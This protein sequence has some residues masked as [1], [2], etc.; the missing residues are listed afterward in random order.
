[1]G[2]SNG[3]AA[4]D[5]Y[6]TSH[7]D[8]FHTF[9]KVD[10]YLFTAQFD[11]TGQYPLHSTTILAYQAQDPWCQDFVNTT[12]HKAET[13][14]YKGA[15]VYQIKQGEKW[16]V[17]IPSNVLTNLIKWYHTISMHAGSSNLLQI[18]QGHF[19][20][21]QLKSN[22]ERIVH[23]CAT[24]QRAKAGSGEYGELAARDP[25]LKPWLEVHVDCM[26]PWTF[27]VAEKDHCFSALTCIDPAS[28]LLEVLLTANTTATHIA[29]LFEQCWLA[30]YPRPQYIVHNNGMEFIGIPFQRMLQSQGIQV[31]HISAY[32]PTANAY[33][34]RTHQALANA[35]RV[36][37][38]L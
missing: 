22:V 6:L 7:I 26:G 13:R 4:E 9:A 36:M 10:C 1:L 21:P 19:F 28:A 8:L 14:E 17:L 37:L 24:C 5:T 25:P 20:H 27:T 18:M 3:T 30:R 23:S 2:E 29:R 11:S 15:R 31:N 35:L 34:E 12:N 33:I 38:I 16:R 32:T